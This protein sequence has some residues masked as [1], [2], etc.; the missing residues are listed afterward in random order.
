M[1]W[2]FSG[3]SRNDPPQKFSPKWA[4]RTSVGVSGSSSKLVVVEAPVVGEVGADQDDVAGH[5]SFHAIADELA[6]SSF[7]EVYQFHFGV[8]VPA[9]VDVRY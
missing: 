6:S 2:M 4:T 7:F 9:V 8:K 5:E 3:R 1:S